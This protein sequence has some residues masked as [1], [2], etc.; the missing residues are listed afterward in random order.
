MTMKLKRDMT[1]RFEEENI[2]IT[3]KGNEDIE[4]IDW[5]YSEMFKIYNVQL[6]SEYG[7][8]SIEIPEEYVEYI[9]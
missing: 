7:E 8:C 4:I 6:T 2:E 1:F 5:V 3:L 9:K